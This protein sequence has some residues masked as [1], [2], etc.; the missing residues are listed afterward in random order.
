MTSPQLFVTPVYA[1]ILT[2]MLILLSV[3]VIKARWRHRV[4]FHDGGVD[5]LTRAIRSHG[6]FIEY[7]PLC[8]LLM[9]LSELNH[10]L[11]WTLYVVGTILL[12]GR[13][14][15]AIG[16]AKAILKLRVYGMVLTFTALIGAIIVLITTFFNV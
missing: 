13:L 5:E 7:V 2:V 10:A 6:N 14:L 11:D 15:H 9:A 4:S 3:R 16:V 1:I 8:L 12:L